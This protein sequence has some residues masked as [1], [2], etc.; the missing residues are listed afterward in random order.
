VDID[1]QHYVPIVRDRRVLARPW[2]VR[3]L[4]RRGDARR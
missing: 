3:F 2:R 1:L 4:V